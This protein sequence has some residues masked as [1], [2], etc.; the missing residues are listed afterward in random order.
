MEI[1]SDP[2]SSSSAEPISGYQGPIQNMYA[3]VIH[4]M[5]K[6]DFEK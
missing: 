5:S 6:A 3:T 1:M 2:H 4:F